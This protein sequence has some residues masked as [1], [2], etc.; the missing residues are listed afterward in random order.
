MDF[1]QTYILYTSGKNEDFKV[2]DQWQHNHQ[3]PSDH[4]IDAEKGHFLSIGGTESA[5]NQACQKGSQGV[6]K[7]S[8]SPDQVDGV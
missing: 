4:E 2:V 5:K 6:A 1:T 7:E 8:K 3:S